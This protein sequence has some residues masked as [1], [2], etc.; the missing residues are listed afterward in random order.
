ME[1]DILISVLNVVSF[2]HFLPFAASEFIY[3]L[4]PKVKF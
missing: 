1:I 2:E 4:E 3:Q